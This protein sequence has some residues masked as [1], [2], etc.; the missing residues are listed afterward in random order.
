VIEHGLLPLGRG[1][2]DHVLEHVDDATVC[3]SVFQA[4]FESIEEGIELHGPG[5]RRE[6]RA[7]GDQQLI[8]RAAAVGQA[9]GDDSG[10]QGAR[11]RDAGHAQHDGIDAMGDTHR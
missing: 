9:L 3:P 5:R 1:A 7:G 6:D 2:G 4:P 11:E 10:D 8:A